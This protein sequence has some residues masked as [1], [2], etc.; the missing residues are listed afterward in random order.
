M[1][2]WQVLYST[3]KTQRV[4]LPTSGDS[5]VA[6]FFMRTGLADHVPSHSEG[7]IASLARIRILAAFGIVWFHTDNAAGRSLG[8][9]GLP[10]FLMVSC[11][12]ITAYSY[13]YGIREF[14]TK[15]ATRLL[16]PWVFWCAVYTVCKFVDSAMRGGVFLN[17]FK[18]NV[19]A[20]G[21]SIH[22]WYL[23]YAF[24]AAV[25]VYVL[26]SVTLKITSVLT[27]LVATCIGAGIIFGSGIIMS[28]FKLPTPL[29]QW[30]FALGSIPIGFAFGRG[31]Y[32]KG[33]R[34]R[35]ILFI[36]ITLATLS[37]C[38]GLHLLGF[39]GL[40]VPYSAA[41][42][43]ACVAHVWHGRLDGF[44]R[45]MDSM[46]YGIYLIHP[47]ISRFIN[48]LFKLDRIPWTSIVLTFVLSSV[49]VYTIKKTILARFV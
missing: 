37:S 21:S 7:R 15:R 36:A 9:A 4:S 38:A 14:V 16:V 22:L 11:S 43:L 2:L 42:I 12:L 13:S 39:Y 8:Y 35:K 44:S 30:V 27:V 26:N 1:D 46:T 32:V 24:I 31:Y 49:I 47:L 5:N 28:E 33:S 45:L 17:E 10:I 41:I 40:V 48:I 20:T 34:Q 23:P 18:I 19:L 6:A 3:Y 25:L 29:G